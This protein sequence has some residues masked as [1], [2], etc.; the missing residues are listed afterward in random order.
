MNPSNKLAEAASVAGQDH[1][2]RKPL[3]CPK[4]VAA[5]TFKISIRRGDAVT[6]CR[7]LLRLKGADVKALW[8][9]QLSTA[10]EDV[11]V[12]SPGVMAEIARLSADP[13]HQR[14]RR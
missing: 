13:Q 2:R 10:F 7:A 12:A 6:A 9:L 5:S 4:A 8:R 14:I 1:D 3:P 11:G